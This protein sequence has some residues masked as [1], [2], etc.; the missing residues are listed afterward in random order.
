MKFL[1]ENTL[2]ITIRLKPT[3]NLVLGKDAAFWKQGCLEEHQLYP[4]LKLHHQLP[5]WEREKEVGNHGSWYPIFI[6][7]C[8]ETSTQNTKIN[9]CN[10]IDYYST[11]IHCPP[12]LL[13][14]TVL[15]ATLP[16]IGNG[17][18][19]CSANGKW[20]NMI[21]ERHYV[22]FLFGIPLAH[23]FSTMG[24]AGPVPRWRNRWGDLNPTFSLKQSHSANPKIPEREKSTFSY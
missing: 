21:W 17:Y 4:S 16:D 6:S 5:V 15:H 7:L 3:Q 18:M 11:N 19:N 13:Q 1:K 9:T 8:P 20:A 12:S 23:L 10:V 2:L 24:R 14:Q 22:A